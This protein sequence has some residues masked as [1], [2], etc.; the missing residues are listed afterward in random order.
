MRNDLVRLG[1]GNVCV[2]LRLFI[3]S[4]VGACTS[5]VLDDFYSRDKIYSKP[6]IA[7]GFWVNFA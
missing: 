3:N 2:F 1:R 6:F 7:L 5:G 4:I